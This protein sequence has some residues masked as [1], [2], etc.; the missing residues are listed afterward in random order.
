MHMS[1]QTSDSSVLGSAPLAGRVTGGGT[2]FGS[3]G[4]GTYPAFVCIDFQGEGHSFTGP[5]EFGVWTN[6]IVQPNAITL[7]TF[8]TQLSIAFNI[9]NRHQC[10]LE[11]TYVL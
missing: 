3:F 11:P 8:G 6:D 9:P 1:H 5:T 4:P 10:I 7:D 2:F